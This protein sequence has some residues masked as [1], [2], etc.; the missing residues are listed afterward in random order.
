MGWITPDRNAYAQTPALPSG[1]PLT[2]EDAESWLD[3]YM[4]Y[5]LHTGDVA[6]AVVV[7]VKNG[8][9]LLEKGY[10]YAD[11]ANRTSVDPKTTLFRF[12]SV[13][14]LFTWTAVMQLVEQGK[15]AL[16]SDVNQYLDFV[17]PPRDGKPVTMRNIMTHT[18]GF[19][20]RL[21]GLIGVE[22]DGVVPL[23]DFLKQY[24]PQRIFAPGGTPAYSNYGAALAGYIV[25]RV[26]GLSFDDYLD[27]HLFA[28]L[29]MA[30]STFRQPL[31][32]SF[33]PELS[34]AYAAGSLPA[35]P[36]EIVGPAPA[37]S[38][39]STGDDMAHFMIA[40]LQN[41]RYGSNQILK[42]ATAE[43][44]HG[45]ALT[46]LPGVNRMLLGFYE[47]NYNGH[48][49]IAHGGDTQ[50]FH[51]DLHL[52]L[53]D[54][55]GLLISVNS[56]GK[57][58]AAQGIRSTLFHEFSDRYFPGAAPAS[59]VDAK[60]AAEHARMIA[61]RY[62]GS[63]RAETTFVNLLYL[64]L[65]P[66]VSDNGDG[67]ISVSSSTSPSGIP[68]K[69]REIAPFQWRE[70]GSKDQLGARVADGRVVRLSFGEFAP[71][72][73]YDR[74]PWWKSAGWWLPV[75]A[76]SLGALVLTCLAWPISALTRRHYRVAPPLSG[77]D[78]KAQRFVRIAC[79]AVAVAFLSWVGLAF[80]MTSILDLISKLN[81]CVMLL[82][83]LSP[84]AFLGG[85]GIGLW[86][87]WAVLKSH[88]RWYA[89]LWSVVLATSLLAL[90]WAAFTVHL[91]SF[92]SG[93]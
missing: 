26:S 78:A 93:Y 58:G 4:P 21:T 63:R 48:R 83:V 29:E 23:G 45:S 62:Q 6:G 1:H 82:R 36:F 60:T 34:K 68:L 17:I 40:H 32:A 11:V 19:E 43:Q 18:A 64:I 8:Q 38:L 28:P 49:V 81:G 5:A 72:E 76:L 41:G 73:M 67:T 84:F 44:M 74:V 65:Q 71:I 70:D 16:D 25:A 87:A 88:R 92:K 47:D 56:I 46:I 39:T 54:G 61:G 27:Q 90:L 57:D 2:T 86:N 14:K 53:D 20:E 85:A 50:W 59:T 89:K 66:T 22:S 15:I 10:G 30:N 77:L 33:K 79:V 80:A 24:I 7:I 3:G 75:L 31:P 13:S 69:W 91:I 9:V 12:G 37:G 52:F 35:Q 51:S 42:S 55:V